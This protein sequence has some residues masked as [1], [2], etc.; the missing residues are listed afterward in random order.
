MRTL[1]EL[2]DLRFSDV[3]DRQRDLLCR[4]VE[5][6]LFWSPVAKTDALLTFSVGGA[7][8]R[9]AAIVEQAFLGITRRLWDDPFEWTL[10][11]KLSS[12]EAIIEYLDEVAAMRRQGLAFLRSDDDLIKQLPAPEQL[13]P[14]FQVLVECLMKAENYLG[15]AE[16]ADK[17]MS[18]S[19][20]DHGD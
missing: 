13:K 18:N 20:K 10:P 1:I 15:R 2:L 7:V 12:I 6:K 14:I 16:A 4:T 19:H 11:E 17:L 8:L 3:D 5:E 9:S